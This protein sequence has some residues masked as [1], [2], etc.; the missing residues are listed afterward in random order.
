M[1]DVVPDLEGA[2]SFCC[3]LK[4]SETVIQPIGSDGFTL[5]PLAL[6]QSAACPVFESRDVAQQERALAALAEFCFL[7]PKLGGSQHPV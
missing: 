2:C 4:H 3:L 7:H 5:S 1:G 6:H